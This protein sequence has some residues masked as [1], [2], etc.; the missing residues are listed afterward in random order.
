MKKLS[1]KLIVILFI[2]IGPLVGYSQKVLVGAEAHKVIKGAEMVRTSPYSDLPSFIRLQ[3]ENGIEIDNV[4]NW[5]K[6]VFKLNPE[7][8]FK[9]IQSEADNIGFVHHKFQQTYKGIPLQDG[10]WNV[11]T[12]HDKVVSLNGLIYNKIV[13]PTIAS[14]S[15]NAA[16]SIVLE[17]IGAEV[18]KWEL[19][20]EEAH[21][22][23]ESDDQTSTYAP[24]GELVLITNNSSFHAN[25]YRLAYKFNVYAH[26]PLSRAD[27]F[28]D[29]NSGEI[30]RENSLIHEVDEEGT[31]ETAYSGTQT[32]TAD[33]FEGIYR[34][35]DASRGNGI[36]TFDL[37]EAVEYGDAVDFEDDDN[38]W[39]NVNPQKDE[40]ATDAHW[41]SEMT[42]DYFFEQ[43]DRN[44][45]DNDGFQLNSY[46]HFGVDYAN[47]FWDGTRMTYGDGD[48]FWDPLTSVDIAGHE[49]THGLTTFTAGLIY[50]RE[51]GALNESFSDIFGNAIEQFARP[52]DFSW[53]VGED[54]GSALRSMSNPNSYG[55]PD[56]YFGDFWASL[57]G[58]DS[59]GVHTN[60]GV[61]NFWFYL[62]SQG[63]TGTNDNGDDYDVTGI[64][65]ED[66]GKIA[67]RNLTVYLTPSSN[68][69]EARFYAIQSATD[70]FGGCT[71]EVEQTTNAWY[72]VGV[73]EIFVPIVEVAFEASETVGCSLPYAINFDNLSINGSTYA[74]F[75]GD[76]DTDDET[77]PEHVYTAAG[78]YDVKLIVD[79]GACGI[80]SLTIEDYIIID[81][82]I[83]CVA[84]LPSDGT[85]PTQSSCEGTLF[86]AGGE[87]GDYPGR[88]DSQI[89]IAPIGADRVDLSFVS[90]NMEAGAGLTC[91]Y[92]YIEIFDGPT[93]FS[94]L[95]DRYCD[96]NIPTDVSSTGGAITIVFHSDASVEGTGFEVEW[97]C[98]VPFDP[99]V[100]NFTSNTTTTCDGLVH[101]VDLT[102]NAPTEWDW[103]FGDGNI[104]SLQNPSH[105]YDAEG[106]Y[107]VQL[108]A[109][110]LIGEN[111]VI[112]TDYITVNYAENPTASGAEICPTENAVLSA[113]G[114]GE[115]QWYDTPVGGTLLGRGASF[116]TEPLDATTTFYVSSDEYETPEF[117]GPAD[118]TFGEGDP[119]DGEQYL[120]FNVDTPI[121]IK[122]VKVYASGS[123]NRTIELRDNEGT[124]IESKTIF[125]EDG[126]QTI[127]LNLSVPIGENYQLGTAAGS[128]PSLFRNDNEAALPSYPYI[129]DDLVEILTSSAGSEYYYHYYNW[130]IHR[131]ECTSDRVAVTATVLDE[132]PITIKSVDDICIQSAP[133]TLEATMPGGTWSATCGA[134]ID[135]MSGEFNPNLAG[136]GEFT[137]A[138]NV[139][140]TCSFVNTI[141]INVVDCLGL[142]D[143]S[144]ANEF[145]VYPNPTNSRVYIKTGSVSAGIINVTDVLGKTISQVTFNSNQVIYNFDS[146]LA[147]GTYF[148]H[149]SDVNGNY[150]TSKKIIKH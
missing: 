32:I 86:D 70:I 110:N 53:L 94:P 52:G 13:A 8:D 136:V 99:P 28:I 121:I 129:I 126:E 84:V 71:F 72:A 38:D 44:S 95:I 4:K 100:A 90:F 57:D 45:I 92:D 50:A 69:E 135:D 132:S 2:A 138:Y 47:A 26:K 93:R 105:T 144:L 150:I 143:N 17:H 119:F 97:T 14:L 11:H 148:I 111:T 64:G 37:N 65:I 74:W 109:T 49:I 20:G 83:E 24:K 43:H 7:M 15:E 107:T 103:D 27:I 145:N 58:G 51:S 21:L 142:E 118:N 137:V 29:A 104:S 5:Y 59:G 60:S 96:N 106:V 133:I 130:E 42:Y 80:D 12:K 78:E 67:F 108:R 68:F 35:R 1:T 112:I 115:M 125:I 131:Y 40:Y 123:K 147:D 120:I 79:G 101:F 33:S 77:N 81:P 62:L 30:L 36:R 140:G 63:G 149:F 61:Q 73:G 89:T 98:V 66:A 76:G 116:T 102:T 3:K 139:E 10:I 48:D 31:A 146:N 113:L 16:L 34:L 85:G 18:Y 22:K 134:C 9:L 141:T 82:T 25:S 23:W 127:D 124:L 114:A 122:R 87:L 55:D 46:I 75:F 19:P 54:I 91:N 39:D 88:S 6:T 41:G 117:V 56:T 128:I